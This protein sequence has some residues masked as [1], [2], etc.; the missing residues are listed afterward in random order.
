MPWKN[1]YRGRRQGNITGHYIIDTVIIRG[2]NIFCLLNWK[3]G[4]PQCHGLV[5]QLHNIRVLAEDSAM[6][7]GFLSW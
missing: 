4:Y 1:M 6:L 2:W 7:Q 3:P 5:Q